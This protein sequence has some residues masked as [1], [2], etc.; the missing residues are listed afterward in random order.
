MVVDEP[1]VEDA[2]SILRG[3]KERFEVHHGVRISDSALVT[4]VTLSSRY[5][6]D[7]QLPDKAIDLIDEAAAMIRT[8]ID[9]LPSELDAASR[10]VMQLEIEETALKREA[11]AASAERLKALQK[12][13]QE[14]RTEADSLRALLRSEERRVGKECRSRWSPYH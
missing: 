4:A 9:S 5:I 3:L 2:I 7:R 1:G 10:R 14:A 12:E 8:E 13:L 11:D 6:S